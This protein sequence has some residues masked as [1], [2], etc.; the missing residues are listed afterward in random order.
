MAGRGVRRSA[1]VDKDLC[2]PV[3]S[4]Q[5]SLTWW[6]PQE[7]A[8]QPLADFRSS[9]LSYAS[10]PSPSY[11]VTDCHSCG[12]ADGR[13][14]PRT[15]ENSG[16]PHSAELPCPA[17]THQELGGTQQWWVQCS[18]VCLS[19]QTFSPGISLVL[20]RSAHPQHRRRVDSRFSAER[21]TRLFPC[22]CK[23]STVNS[24]GCLN[25]ISIPF[26]F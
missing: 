11:I 16:S 19:V 13:E 4:E 20:A 2:R 22:R 7:S 10:Q 5:A 18:G 9:H 1:G 3:G 14:G 23:G 17:Q 26:S 8:T 6:I 25:W 24:Q 15:L 12:W 21:E